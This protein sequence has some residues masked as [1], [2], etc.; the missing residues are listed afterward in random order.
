MKYYCNLEIKA[1]SKK[2]AE[3]Y[4]YMLCVSEVVVVKAMGRVH[5]G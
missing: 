2:D 4:V 1:K 5:H 3:E